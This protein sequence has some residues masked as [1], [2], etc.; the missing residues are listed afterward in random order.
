MSLTEQQIGL[1]LY[2]TGRTTNDIVC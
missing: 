2:K 1:K